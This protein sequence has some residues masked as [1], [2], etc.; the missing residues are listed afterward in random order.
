MKKWRI[1]GALGMLLAYSTGA[2]ATN[3]WFTSSSP[4]QISTPSIIRNNPRSIALV[5]TLA[6][7]YTGYI[8]Y[9]YQKQQ[10][11]RSRAKHLYNS[12][13]K[14]RL[15]LIPHHTGSTAVVAVHGMC[16]SQDL[17]DLCVYSP[18]NEVGFILPHTQVIAFN[19]PDATIDFAKAARTHYLGKQYRESK[20]GYDLTK[21]DWERMRVAS[22]AQEK[23]INHLED[24]VLSDRAQCHHNL[25]LAGVSRGAATIINYMGSRLPPTNIKAL[26]LDAPFDAIYDMLN[27]RLKLKN[28]HMV[29]LLT[30]MFEFYIT[31]LFKNYTPWGIRPIDV[32]DCIPN[33]PILMICSLEDTVVPP[34]NTMRLYKKLIKDG[35]TNVHLFIT[36]HGEHGRIMF[37]AEHPEV[38]ITYRNIV[39]AFLQTYAL[40]HEPTW[41]TAGHDVFATCQPSVEYLNKTYAI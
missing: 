28:L 13:K 21:E 26:I 17:A 40:E 19:F 11:I 18:D 4:F 7:T 41:A 29:P 10:E 39:H 23:D 3:F 37:D 25:V 34:R 6:V 2:M 35:R 16:G 12:I 27:A 15:Y 38:G 8:L 30:T 32:V 22:L 5:S 24:A 20:L 9:Q 33:I 14:D 31:Y 1:Y 36:K